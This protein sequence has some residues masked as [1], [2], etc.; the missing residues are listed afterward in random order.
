MAVFE[1]SYNKFLQEFGA[2][3][4][5]GDHVT[6]MGPTGCGKTWLCADLLQM[7]R[8]VVVICSKSR[9]RT[10]QRFHGYRILD[11]WDDRYYRDT[12]V[13]IWPKA[14]TL[15]EAKANLRPQIKKALDG[16]YVEGGWTA[17]LDDLKYLCTGLGLKADIETMYGQVRSNDSSLVGCA[18]RPYGMVQPALDQ[19]THWLMFHQS[20]GRD[21]DRMAEVAGLNPKMVSASNEQVGEFQFLWFRRMA[22]PVLV[23]RSKQ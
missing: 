4:K 8:Y 12:K 18:Q 13:I 22:E 11:D 10:I 20:D 16:I 23:R 15:D 2:G 21:T 9:D 19:A 3:W 7:R 1:Y 6:V 5:Q 14:R 17:N